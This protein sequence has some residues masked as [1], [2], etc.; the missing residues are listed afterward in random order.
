MD[1]RKAAEGNPACIAELEA[2][3]AQ[4]LLGRQYLEAL[5]KEVARLGG[6]AQTG[7]DRQ[8]MEA[9]TKRL[10]EPEL[11]KLKASY[12]QQAQERYPAGGVQLTYHGEKAAGEDRDGA[13]LI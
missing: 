4:A 6:L 9:I 13:F 12:E 8:T 2:L 7:L 5:R 1:L 10:E 11:R 3:E